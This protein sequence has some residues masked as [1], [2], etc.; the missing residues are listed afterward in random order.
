MTPVLCS[1]THLS[2]QSEH[3]LFGEIQAY[4]EQRERKLAQDYGV[5]GLTVMPR[6][7]H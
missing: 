3:P 7:R 1:I 2:I 6:K 5:A 4:Q